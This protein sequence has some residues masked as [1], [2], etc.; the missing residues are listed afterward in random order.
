MGRA[1]RSTL[2]S[3]ALG[4]PPTTVVSMPAPLWPLGPGPSDLELARA[5]EL[6][7]RGPIAVLTGAGCST[8]SGIPDYRGEGTL[9]RARAPVRFATFLADPQ[10]RRR[11]WARSVIGWPRLAQARPNLAHRALA[12]LEARGR[13]TGVLTQNVDRLHHAAGSQR[14]I[15]LHGALHQVRCL[16]CGRLED[17]QALQARLLAANPAFAHRA[18]AL[19]PDG[20]AE[21]PDAHVADFA[22]ATCEACGGDLKP[23]VVFFGES[24]PRARVEAA[25][26]WVDDSAALLVLGSSLTVLSGLRF[27]RRAHAAGRPIVIVNQGETRGDALAALKLPGR[28][29]QVLPDLAAR[30]A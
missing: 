8:E 22:V 23:D 15:E 1:W 24:V 7:G 2:V 6:L 26:R 20:D 4:A 17:R 11:Y 19:N 3:L 28:L 16:A 27:V 21:L 13:V 14:V 25:Y 10:A 9:R 30:L 12:D 5:A 18:A 29:A